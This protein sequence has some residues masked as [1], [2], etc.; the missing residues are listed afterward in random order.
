MRNY[1]V[2]F[3][4]LCDEVA[5]RSLA[6]L[7]GLK[8]KY[9]EFKATLFVIPNRTSDSN[10]AEFRQHEWIALA[11]HGWHHTRGECLTWAY[12]EALAKLKLAYQKGIRA[13]AFRAPAWLINR[14]TYEACRDM[15]LTICDHSENYLHVPHTQVYRYNDPAFRAPKTEPIHGHLT[16]TTAV[17]NFIEDMEADGRLSFADGS[18]FSFP[19]E[20]GKTIGE[21]P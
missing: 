8:A 20:V 18:K 1:C 14:A 17:D 6:I 7:L 13:P 10:I 16:N 2:D 11:P 4:D 21:K 3:D 12:H 9:P 5:E 19:W 15:G